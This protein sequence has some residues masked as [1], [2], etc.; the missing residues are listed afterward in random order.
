MNQIGDITLIKYLGKGSFGEVFLSTKAGRREYFATK[1]IDRKKAD[2]PS[3]RKYF[4]NEIA[5]LN[6]LHHPNIVRLEDLKTTNDYYYIVMEYINGGS[7]TDCLKKYQ[8]IYRRSFPEEIVQYIMRQIVDAIKYI[9]SQKIIHR[10]LKLDNIMV[11]FDNDIDKNNLN[12]M[13][14]RVKIIDFGFAIHLSKNAMA[15]S[16]LGSPINM[17]PLIL[18]KFSKKGGDINNLGYDSKADIWSLGT[19]CYEM[20]IGQAVFNAETMND[21]V[22]KVENGSYSVPTN[23]SK[24]IVSFLNG[25]LQYN[26]DNRLSAEEL[27]QHDFLTKRISDFTKIDTRRVSKKITNKGLNINVKQNQ[28]IWAIFNE[29]DEKN[30]LNIRGGKNLPHHIKKEDLNIRNKRANTDKNIP[31]NIFNNKQ[32]INKNISKANSNQ[33]PN[34]GF[35]GGEK[36]FYGQNMHLDLDGMNKNAGILQTPRIPLMQQ[37]TNQMPYSQMSNYPTFGHMPYSYEGSIYSNN[38]LNIPSNYQGDYMQNQPSIVNNYPSFNRRK[39][40]GNPLCCFQ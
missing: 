24:E 5:I 38:N 23:L 20:L 26:G 40:E 29:E 2:T 17:D 33:Y 21:L 36:S 30:L 8:K 25:M 16:A 3:I 39:A 12:M 18:Q 19:I 9:H 37:E 1:K 22:K 27:A 31:R 35:Y 6:S 11:S 14:A 34:F 28:T 15:Y 4:E 13:R 7:L 10:D 32:D